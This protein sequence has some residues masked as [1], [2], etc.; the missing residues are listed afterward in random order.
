MVVEDDDARVLCDVVQHGNRF[1]H[2]RVIVDDDPLNVLQRLAEYGRRRL[3][4]DLAR[5]LR[6][7]DD[8]ENGSGFVDSTRRN[9]IG[10]EEELVRG[11]TVFRER[12][13]VEMNVFVNVMHGEG[14]LGESERD[15]EGFI[16]PR[17]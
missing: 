10:S 9:G 13:V 11:R 14:F 16:A 15:V 5:V 17:D 8:R 1:R 7:R 4:H 12:V 6:R 3:E 2:V